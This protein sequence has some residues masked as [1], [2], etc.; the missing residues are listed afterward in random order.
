MFAHEM[1]FDI[2]RSMRKVANI[3]PLAIGDGAN[4]IGWTFWIIVMHTKGI[5]AVMRVFSQKNSRK[6]EAIKIF[7]VRFATR[8]L[9]NLR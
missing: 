3:T 5:V 8:E 9:K 4:G 1:F 6:T 2:E 7:G